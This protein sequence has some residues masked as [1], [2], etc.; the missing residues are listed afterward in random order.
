MKYSNQGIQLNFQVRVNTSSLI[1]KMPETA[2]RFVKY[3]K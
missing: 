2:S 1:I 3:E